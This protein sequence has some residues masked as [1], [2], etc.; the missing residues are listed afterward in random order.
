MFRA[1]FCY[2]FRAV[3]CYIFAS[4]KQVGSEKTRKH[5]TRHLGTHRRKTR[6]RPIVFNGRTFFTTPHS[7]QASFVSL[8]LIQN[9]ACFC[10]LQQI[11]WIKCLDGA[12]RYVGLKTCTAGIKEEVCISSGQRM[13]PSGASEAVETAGWAEN[14]AFSNTLHMIPHNPTSNHQQREVDTATRP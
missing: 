12:H 1:V 14:H 7:S 2:K 11:C 8:Y 3:F 5:D 13:S 10:E 6:L 4:K 9:T